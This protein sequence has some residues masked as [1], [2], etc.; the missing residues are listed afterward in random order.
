MYI[1]VYCIYIYMYGWEFNSI[2]TYVDEC[3]GFEWSEEND[4]ALTWVIEHMYWNTITL[5][6]WLVEFLYILWKLNRVFVLLRPTGL[7]W[8]SIRAIM[9]LR[10]CHCDLMSFYW[11]LLPL[12]WWHCTT[13]ASKLLSS[14]T[15]LSMWILFRKLHFVPKI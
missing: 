9:S 4:S 2:Y 7:F 6:I 5:S 14:F 3:F 10:P 13:I 11:L 1:Y 12:L 8:K 15:Y